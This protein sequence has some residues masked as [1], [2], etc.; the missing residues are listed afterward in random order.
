M[1]KKK[2]KQNRERPYNRIT[3]AVLIYLQTRIYTRVQIGVFRINACAN[4]I[5][6][7]IIRSRECGR[8]SLINT[9]S[10]LVLNFLLFYY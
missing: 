9:P 4:I 5:F 10:R 8:F 1:R 7:R 3:P 6:T 2:Q